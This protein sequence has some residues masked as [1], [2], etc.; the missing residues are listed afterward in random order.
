MIEADSISATMYEIFF[1]FEQ[2]PEFS[3]RNG[4]KISRLVDRMQALHAPRAHLEVA[5]A[6]SV[7]VQRLEWARFNQQQHE[8]ASLHEIISCLKARWHSFPAPRCSEHPPGR[9]AAIEQ[10]RSLA[11]D[12]PRTIAS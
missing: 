5:R 1:D 12:R 7:T 6:L 3:C 11:E 4:P 2:S 8:L 10:D 9:A